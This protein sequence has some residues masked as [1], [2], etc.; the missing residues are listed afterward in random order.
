[1]MILKVTTKFN[2]YFTDTFTDEDKFTKDGV[3]VVSKFI[4]TSFNLV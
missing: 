3:K 2:S 4:E 1:M